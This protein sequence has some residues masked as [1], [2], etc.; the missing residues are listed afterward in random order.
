MTQ[1]RPAAPQSAA[2]IART[3]DA[4]FHFVCPRCFY[5]DNTTIC[6]YGRMALQFTTSYVGDSIGIFRYYKTL[7]QRAMQQLTDEQLFAVLRGEMMPI[8]VIVEHIP[9]NMRSP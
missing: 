2:Y 3:D 9:G 5:S 8:A 1:L 7:A 6:Q 4:D